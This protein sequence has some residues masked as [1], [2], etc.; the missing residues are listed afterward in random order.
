MASITYRDLLARNVRAR[1]AARQI[2][3]QELA[4]RMRRLGF[5]AWAHQAVSNVERGKR[6]LAAE[7]ILG[8]ALALETTMSDLLLPDSDDEP[9]ALPSGDEVPANSV[10]RVILAS[11]L[12]RGLRPVTWEDGKPVFH[13][14]IMV[15]GHPD[16]PLA[17]IEEALDKALGKDT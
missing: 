11:A 2:G 1:R 16:R 7:E 12:S 17:R 4:A 9:V 8:L 10:I 5:S 6:R 13:P 14:E 15:R 3:Q